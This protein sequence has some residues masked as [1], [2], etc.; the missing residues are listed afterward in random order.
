M[1]SVEYSTESADYRQ[2]YAIHTRPLV[3]SIFEENNF[4]SIDAVVLEAYH[5]EQWFEKFWNTKYKKYHDPLFLNAQRTGKPVYITDVIAT[6]TGIII[7]DMTLLP[8]DILGFFGVYDGVRAVH[9][10]IEEKKSLTRREFFKFWGRE[11]VKIMG[12]AYLATHFIH[13]Q[14]ALQIGDNPELLARLHSLRTHLV[15]TPQME[16]R[17]AISARKIEGYVVPEL[18]QQLGRKPKILLV[19]GAGHSGLKED[20]QHK[21]LRDL[22]ISLYSSLGFFGIDTTYLDVVT[23]LSIDENGKYLLKHRNANLF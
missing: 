20:L 5:S 7:E 22:N 13:Q 11:S 4:N 10:Q 6:K 21:K 23:N 18:Q 16:L 19:N 15:P 12:G 8:L 1:S 3:D 2:I 14:Y 9:K 17:N